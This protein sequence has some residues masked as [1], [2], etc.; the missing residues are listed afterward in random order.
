MKIKSA[1]ITS[2]SGSIGGLTASHNRG[3][4]YLRARTIPTNPNSPQQQVVRAFVASLTSAW[5]NTLTELQRMAWDGYALLVPLPDPLGE[6]RN[7]GGLQ[8]YIRSNVPRL[9]AGLVRVD[10]A[11]SIYNLA[12][13]YAIS[14]GTFAAAT[15][16]FAV[17]FD[18][19]QLW[20][21]ETGG[22][23]VALGSRPQNN[24]I[25]YFKGPYRFAG[26]IEG[27]P[28]TPPTSPATIVN[29]FPFAVD[30]RVFVQLR[31]MRADGRLSLPFRDFGLGA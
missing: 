11:P 19:T 30:N 9:Q 4:L 28:I 13:F 12:D 5:L 8:M 29:P 24:S 3:G 1:L 27:D 15:N 31:V 2:A 23:V 17:T 7:V 10:D 21:N 20:A 6:P 22:A 16:D 25:N 26:V 14:V 18:N